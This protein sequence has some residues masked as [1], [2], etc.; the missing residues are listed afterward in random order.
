[1]Q[2]G[3][4][5]SLLAKKRLLVISLILIFV[6]TTFET[7]LSLSTE[8]YYK[9]NS[10]RAESAPYHQS[11]AGTPLV[12][13]CDPLGLDSGAYSG[14][15]LSYSSSI[16]NFTEAANDFVYA[17]AVVQDSQPSLDFIFQSNYHMQIFFNSS[18][19]ADCINPACSMLSELILPQ[20][21]QKFWMPNI[22]STIYVYDLT[23]TMYGGLASAT[24]VSLDASGQATQINGSV[25]INNNILNMT[26]NYGKMPSYTW[27]HEFTHI[28][29]F[30]A[31]TLTS[32]WVT[33][34]QASFMPYI[35]AGPNGLNYTCYDVPHVE[36]A[37]APSTCFSS[38]SP[39]DGVAF[40]LE[41]RVN[42]LAIYSGAEG[43]ARL[44][45]W[46]NQI[47]QKLYSK[48][49]SLPY[50]YWGN[51]KSQGQGS[52][53]YYRDLII[54]K[55]STNVIDSVDISQWFDSHGF[56]DLGT[57]PMNIPYFRWTL[58]YQNSRNNGTVIIHSAYVKN[59]TNGVNCQDVSYDIKLFDALS[60]SSLFNRTGVVDSNTTIG[61]AFAPS[62]IG[63]PQ[64]ITARLSANVSG[65]TIVQTKVF[66]DTSG[67]E[68]IYGS[69]NT[70]SISLLYNKTAMVRFALKNNTNVLPINQ[71]TLNVTS[72]N[73]TNTFSV[74]AA[75]AQINE[76][77]FSEDSPINATLVFPSVNKKLVNQIFL[78]CT[79][80]IF[81]QNQT[82]V[83]SPPIT[84]DDYDNSLYTKPF[85]I[86]LTA[87]S[88]NNI[89]NT[90]Y[91]ING[92]NTLNVK[93]SKQPTFNSS[94]IFS[95]SDNTLE[96]WSRDVYYNEEY[97]H[98]LIHIKIDTGDLVLG[99]FTVLTLSNLNYTR[100][101]NIIVRDNA[102]L[103]LN[104]CNLFL[105]QSSLNQFNIQSSNYGSIVC[106][107]SSISSNF[108]F[109]QS[110]YGSNANF[111]RTKWNVYASISCSSI[112]VTDSGGLGYA[113]VSNIGY[114][115]NCSG[116]SYLV[117]AQTANIKVINCTF[118]GVLIYAQ[119]AFFNTSNLRTGYINYFNSFINLTVTS[120][121]IANLTIVNS[122]I[123][124]G[125]GFQLSL[126][127]NASFAN[128]DFWQVL[129]YDNSSI[130]IQGSNLTNLQIAQQGK[131]SVY[132]STLNKLICSSSPNG[133]ALLSNVT[134][135]FFYITQSN[136][137]LTGNFSLNNC[138]ISQWQNGNVTVNYTIT[139]SQNGTLL[140]YIPLTVTNG[141][142]T[143][144]NGFTD[145]NGQANINVT[146]TNSNYTSTLAL[147]AS[148]GKWFGSTNIAFLGNSSIVLNLLY[149]PTLS[150][151]G[152]T[153]WYWTNNTQVNAVVAGDVDGD[154]KVEVVTAGTYFD[155]SRTCAQL[156]EWNAATLT[157]KRVTFWYWNSNT[158]VKSVAIGDVDGDG[159][160]EIITGGYYWD[161]SRNCA[162]LIEWKGADL[163]VDRLTFWYWTGNTVVNSVGVGDVDGDG[164][165][166]V[167]TAGSFV[168][169]GGMKAQLIEWT[170][171]ALVPERL[172]FW[173]WFG[174]T[175]VNSVALGDV[176]NDGQVEVVTGGYFTDAGVAKAQ[177][178][179][180]AGSSLVPE[181]L[182]F[183]LWGTR[184]VVNSVAVGDAD[185][186]G[187]TEIVT[188]GY[189]TDSNGLNAQLLELHGSNLAYE[190][191]T[192]WIWSGDTV[193]NSVAIA[194]LDS[195][196]LQEIVTGGYFTQGGVLNAQLIEW[197]GS[198]LSVDRLTSWYLNRDT[199]INSVAVGDVNGDFQTEVVTGGYCFD[200]TRNWSQLTVWGLT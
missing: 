31:H 102:R 190:L 161:G 189:Y 60:G 36:Y 47:F 17:N 157:V 118:P 6:I 69:N 70:Y 116:S 1:V 100:T 92:G 29:Q 194:D 35:V 78:R 88:S 162:Q 13:L 125:I 59:S 74:N 132:N 185:G 53:M 183:W 199:T 123:P 99:G 98:T 32:S 170:G 45:L 112:N 9:D 134:V 154:S 48:L 39:M 166:E 149:H 186:D 200:G 178:I 109:S 79:D 72:Q 63:N 28:F 24:P 167:V 82:M 193:V 173:Q 156:I 18:F 5:G 50:N 168:D 105:N 27:T 20:L 155:G 93:D 163:S 81:F 96:Y 3:E 139:A 76:T 126:A 180:W 110:F 143:I 142:N 195:D 182:T 198:A 197:V 138:H 175:A 171:A 15:D 159:Q 108:S 103:I 147:I 95:G 121:Q 117:G 174:N 124:T 119:K 77:S 85:T 16:P 44:Y 12:L 106:S 21:S 148:N 113:Y 187:Q 38:F 107:D 49:S 133:T 2:K 101:G 145:S 127:S 30:C 188:G 111:S 158:S 25:W 169:A 65:Q 43:W 66:L 33:E 84:I 184:S 51:A 42:W 136:L 152:V 146:Y 67:K 141:S 73:Y 89:S 131:A 7:P 34:A 68:A 130:T 164:Q 19:P 128:S 153:A 4:E 58:A 192:H 177:L 75:I 191:Q 56:C 57:I 11:S 26:A 165:V 71:A 40:Y 181:R 97:P 196:G 41:T 37:I 86:H 64:A 160:I 137:Y 83:A 61:F 91:S 8:L 94:N 10:S 140:D 87:T 120:G 129:I 135:S 151:E 54:Q 46:D 115:S 104:N 90:F 179:E 80:D 55:I 14:E 122:N 62:L 172:T 22:N 114:F 52:E 176:D 144:W 23:S 150:V